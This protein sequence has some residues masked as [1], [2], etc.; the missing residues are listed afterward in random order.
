MCSVRKVIWSA[1]VAI[2]L[3]TKSRVEIW[4]WAISQLKTKWKHDPIYVRS[5]I[6]Y[7]KKKCY[8]WKG[9]TYQFTFLN[10]RDCYDYQNSVWA[11]FTIHCV[12][13][14]R[15]VEQ[16]NSLNEDLKQSDLAPDPDPG[17][18]TYCK[19][20]AFLFCNFDNVNNW[21]RWDY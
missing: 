6:V 12:Y 20:I 19:Y 9:Q 13:S 4:V 1:V 15:V 16:T 11:A 5:I 8:V 2:E 18:L 14:C 3:R 17:C 10:Q 7:N 21:C